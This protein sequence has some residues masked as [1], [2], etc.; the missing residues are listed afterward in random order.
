MAWH[1]MFVVC[2]MMASKQAFEPELDGREIAQVFFVLAWLT[3][4]VHL[5][6]FP[7]IKI[8]VKKVH[9]IRV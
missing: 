2:R 7:I 8:T 1:R 3:I 9:A 5:Y 4:P 6:S